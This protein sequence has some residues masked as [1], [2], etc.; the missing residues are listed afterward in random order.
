MSLKSIIYVPIIVESYSSLF[1]THA[2]IINATQRFS[3]IG[4]RFK[5]NGNDEYIV[6]FWDD[7]IIFCT[8]FCLTAS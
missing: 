5:V 7:K 2:D 3:F 8:K 1:N 6:F 4:T